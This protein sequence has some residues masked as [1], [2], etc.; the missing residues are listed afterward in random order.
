MPPFFQAVGCEVESRIETGELSRQCVSTLCWAFGMMRLRNEN[1]IH[2]LGHTVER[3]CFEARPLEIANTAYAFA[4]LRVTAVPLFLALSETCKGKLYTFKPQEL[5]DVLWAFARLQFQ[6][7]QLFL[8]AAGA[9]IAHVN[10]SADLDA[11]HVATLTWAFAK[12]EVRNV[13]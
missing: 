8:E 3:N 7:T 13:M 12:L 11:S 2:R 6:C 10:G 5:A 4:S 9:T 1:L